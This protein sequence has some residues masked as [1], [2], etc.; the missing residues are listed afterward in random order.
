LNRKSAIDTMT[1]L[2]WQKSFLVKTW[3]SGTIFKSAIC[4]KIKMLCNN[5]QCKITIIY[6]SVNKLM[7]W[8]HK[9]LVQHMVLTQC[10]LPHWCSDFSQ[11]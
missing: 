8:S 4:L 5:Q 3:I 7:D 9:K 2:S 11:V 1:F 6:S 10:F